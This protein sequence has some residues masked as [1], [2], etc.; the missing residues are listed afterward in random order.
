MSTYY[1]RQI[2]GVC[3]CSQQEA[4]HI[5]SVMRDDIVHG[6]LDWLDKKQF[7]AAALRA[8]KLYREEQA[9]YDA[10]FAGIRAFFQGKVR[11]GDQK[12]QATA[13]ATR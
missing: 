4:Q 12:A 1:A 2:E 11:E 9:T 8:Q 5:E 3:G 13:T 10:Y 7:R 6:T